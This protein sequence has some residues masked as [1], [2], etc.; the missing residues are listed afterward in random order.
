MRQL[1]IPGR[2]KL[3][4]D[5]LG[6]HLPELNA[7][8]VE[9]IDIPDGAL[10]KH[11]VLIERDKL[12]KNL[13]R[14]HIPEDRVRRS[15]TLEDLVWNQPIRRSFRLYLLCS[16]AEGQRFA[17]REHI[18][19]QQIVMPAERI[20]RSR[21]SNK[22]AR[23]QSRPL[24]DELIKAVLSVRAGFAPVNRPRLIGHSLAVERDMLSV[25]LHSELLQISREAFQILLIR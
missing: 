17:L 9:R 5:P 16:L 13:G 12:A 21:K 8:L 14:E 1:R 24:V 19:H 15:V 25:G 2:L 7:P 3:A 10:R 6:Q 20:Q 18:R 23:N 22:V 11:A 4:D